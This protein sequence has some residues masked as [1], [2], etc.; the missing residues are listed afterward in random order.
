MI[1]K[2]TSEEIEILKKELTHASFWQVLVVLFWMNFKPRKRDKF[3][4]AS[5][6]GCTFSHLMVRL[7]KYKMS[8]FAG[9]AFGL[10]NWKW[11]KESQRGNLT[12]LDACQMPCLSV[13]TKIVF[14]H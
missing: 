10:T 4:N 14:Y 5:K 12:W 9:G 2:L 6:M 11:P 3:L 13:D 1:R 8:P 7:A